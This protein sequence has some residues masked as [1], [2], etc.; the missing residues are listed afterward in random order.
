[1]SLLGFVEQARNVA[2]EAQEKVTLLPGF[3][4]QVRVGLL[5]GFGEQARVVVVSLRSCCLRVLGEA[6]LLLGFGE[7][8]GVVLLLGFGKG[9]YLSFPMRWCARGEVLSKKRWCA[10][11]EL[12]NWKY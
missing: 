6:A 11:K 8:V 3:G 4:E 1:M 7:Q 5:S 12:V 10:G 9:Y 2:C